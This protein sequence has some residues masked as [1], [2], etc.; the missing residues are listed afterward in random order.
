M[1][2]RIEEFGAYAEITGFKGVKFSDAEAFLKENRKNGCSD[3]EM[4]FFDAELI[5][6]SRHLYFAVLNALQA[7][8]NRTNLSKS[9]AVETM[10]YASAQRQIQ[11][12]IQR[13]GIKPQ[14][15]NMAVTI[16]SRDPAEIE[17]LARQIRF[18]IGA[19][20]DE[21]VLEMTAKKIEKIK[22]TFQIKDEEIKSVMKD[23]DF[24]AAVVNLVIERVALLAV[25]L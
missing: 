22:E 13:S 18:C 25:Q 11:R 2:H 19:E 3:V 23:N 17:L 10:L 6:T 1:L 8:Q 16:L 5:A 9:L 14:T 15:Q 7:F 24:E 21:T 4:Q 20:P 12:A